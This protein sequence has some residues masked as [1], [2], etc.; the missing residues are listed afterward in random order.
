MEGSTYADA[1]ARFGQNEG[2]GQIYPQ[3]HQD[4]DWVSSNKMTYLFVT[5]YNKPDTTNLKQIGQ[6]THIQ[7]GGSSG[8]SILLT[9]QSHIQP[10]G[11]SGC[12]IHHIQVEAGEALACLVGH[13]SSQGE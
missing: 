5:V 10:D 1:V 2:N 3:E 11:R 8:R 4:S 12:S 9:S 6:H 13:L 7:L